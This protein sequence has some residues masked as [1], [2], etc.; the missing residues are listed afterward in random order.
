MLPMMV[1][2]MAMEMTMLGFASGRRREVVILVVD[3]KDVAES[4]H[5]S[6]ALC[7]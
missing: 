4:R 5:F 2:S 3:G 1:V 6:K 7:P